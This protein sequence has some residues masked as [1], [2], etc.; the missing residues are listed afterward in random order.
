[1]YLYE[2]QNFAFFHQWK[3]G[4]TSVYM[5]LREK[6]GHANLHLGDDGAVPPHKKVDTFAGTRLSVHSRLRTFWV[7]MEEM[8]LHP[9]SWAMYANVRH[10]LPRMVSGWAWSKRTGYTD[11]DFDDWFEDIF[12]RY[13]W[14]SVYLRVDGAVP[15][16]VTVIRLEDA[17][18][19]WPDLIEYHFGTRLSYPPLNVSGLGEMWK[20]YLTGEQAER[21]LEKEAWLMENYYV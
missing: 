13:R 6:F 16:N 18:E 3:C 4:G 19:K 7:L 14:Q 8:N 9:D 2:K 5:P 21:V 1:M 15:D 10:P 12:P 11:L 20:E 17:A